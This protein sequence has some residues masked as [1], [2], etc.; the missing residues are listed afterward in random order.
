MFDIK[1][2]R[3]TSD[4]TDRHPLARQMDDL[5]GLATEARDKFLGDNW[6]KDVE[7]LYNLE[8]AK[9]PSPSFRPRVVIPQL[10]MLGLSEATDMS[11]ADP[12]VIICNAKDG[13]R[14]RNHEKALMAQW[15]QGYFAN[16][17]LLAN[18][19]SFFGGQAF[20]HV[21]HD[22]RARGG[23]GA[24]WIKARNPKHVFH[25]PTADNDRDWGFVIIEDYVWLDRVRQI[26]PEQGWK[27]RPR[28]SAKTPDLGD[29]GYGFQ[30]PA[31]PMALTGGPTGAMKS[32]NEGRVRLRLLYCRDASVEPIEGKSLTV[33][34][35]RHR[36]KYP[37]GRLIIECEGVIL[38]DDENPTPHGWFPLVTFRGLPALSGPWNPPPTRYSESLQRLAERM[39]TQVFENAVRLN[40]GI[41]TINEQSG[42]TLDAF[43]GLPAEVH[44]VNANSGPNPIN[45]AYPPPMPPH[46]IELP[47]FLLEMQRNLQGFTPARMGEPGAGNIASSMFDM[48]IHQSQKLTRLR[49]RLMAESL[50]RLVEMVFYTM[51]KFYRTTLIPEFS[52]NEQGQSEFQMTE[53]SDISESWNDYELFLDEDSIKAVSGA[54]MRMMVPMLYQ[55]GLLPPREALE[56]LEIPG[57]EE[58]AKKLELQQ[59]AA[60]L[61]GY[62]K[63]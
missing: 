12:R 45:I 36:P 18:L 32:A 56:M 20:V 22:P 28:M 44:V 34:A 40:N 2:E 21:G 3:K 16:Q 39:L 50:Q 54:S 31:G 7:D 10:Q 55:L 23:R 46:M 57:A 61:A 1:T 60:V 41:V 24:V 27:V 29:P 26:W 59:Q 11:D 17:L 4:A 47:K 51:A 25:D 58:L 8:D 6:Y 48:S 43:G 19:W 42:I 37:N 38:F 53:W 30:M 33:V 35:P 49:G 52:K 13:S 9:L 63:K 62:K 5:E 14:Q 15:R